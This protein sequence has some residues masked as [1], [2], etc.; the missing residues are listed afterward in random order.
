MS[1]NPVDTIEIRP[2]EREAL[3]A[4]LVTSCDGDVSVAGFFHSLGRALGGEDACN[5]YLKSGHYATK[6]GHHGLG[7][8]N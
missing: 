1:D 8:A 2:G 5:H 3:S 7:G 6:G 4:T